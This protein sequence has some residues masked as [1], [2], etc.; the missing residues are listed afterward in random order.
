MYRKPLRCRC[1][2]LPTLTACTV[3]GI[4]DVQS[5]GDESGTERGREVERRGC[6]PISF[7][8]LDQKRYTLGKASDG[9]CRG[10]GACRYAYTSC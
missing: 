1:I 10:G 8:I 7:T 4:I 9:A 3:E 6:C 5:H 2:R